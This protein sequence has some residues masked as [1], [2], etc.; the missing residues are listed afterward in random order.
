MADD[1][2]TFLVLLALDRAPLYGYAIRKR[3]LELSGGS[4]ELEPGG[5]YRLMAALERDALIAPT[6]PPEGSEDEDSRRRYYAL[7]ADGR[8]ALAEEAVRLQE[9]VERSEVRRVLRRA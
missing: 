2:R 5:L 4:V 8:R 3:V 7:T 9:L 1:N 6:D